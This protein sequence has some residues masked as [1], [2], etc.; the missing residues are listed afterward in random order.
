MKKLLYLAAPYTHADPAIMESRFN[1]V[2]KKAAEL[3]RN[4]NVVFSPISHSH[5]I[6]WAGNLPL[7][8]WEFWE[9]QDMPYLHNSSILAV[10]MLDG[11]EESKGVAA[12]I[13][14]A[15]ELRIP[16]IYLQES[17]YA[18]K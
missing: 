10:L 3:M 5:P 14:R 4:G 15:D 17:D 1:A 16:I 8:D 11:W 7:T 2:N 12:E 9:H 18:T 13:K 6:A